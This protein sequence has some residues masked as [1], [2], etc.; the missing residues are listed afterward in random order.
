MVIDLIRLHALICS[1]RI[2]FLTGGVG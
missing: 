2:Q 1:N